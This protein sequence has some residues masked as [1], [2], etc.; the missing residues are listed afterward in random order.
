MRYVNHYVNLQNGKK[1]FIYFRVGTNVGGMWRLENNACLFCLSS[2]PVPEI[3][4]K[5]SGLEEGPWPSTSQTTLPD[6]LSK[7][8]L[9]KEYLHIACLIQEEPK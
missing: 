5:T 7:I 4:T 6:F 3:E 2:M 1:K 9:S 8:K